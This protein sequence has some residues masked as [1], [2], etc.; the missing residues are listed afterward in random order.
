[1]ND[2]NIKSFRRF[3]KENNAYAAFIRNYDPD[4]ANM[5]MEMGGKRSLKYY[6]SYCCSEEIFNFAFLWADTEEGSKFWGNLETK[7][8]REVWG[9]TRHFNVEKCEPL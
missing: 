6:L 9:W 4:Y 2:Y 3:L 5:C 7:W 1:M 8:R